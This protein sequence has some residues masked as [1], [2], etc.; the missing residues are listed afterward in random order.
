MQV[1][2]QPGELIY[3][4]RGWWHTVINL[5]GKKKKILEFSK[6]FFFPD[7]IAV[8]QNFVNSQNLKNCLEDLLEGGHTS[9]YDNFVEKLLKSFPKFSTVV[10]GKKKIVVLK[11]KIKKNNRN[12]RKISKKFERLGTKKKI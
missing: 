9:A 7:T 10:K 3:V 11:K 6:N 12:G 5:D 2:Q 4:P 1:V 8:T